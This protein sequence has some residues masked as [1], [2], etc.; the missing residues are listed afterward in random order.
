MVFFSDDDIIKGIRIKRHDVLKYIYSQ[1]FDRIKW[2]L[3]YRKNFTE[4][5]AKDIFQDSLMAIYKNI[6]KD[7]FSIKCSFKTYLFSVVKKM[8]LYRNKLRA[9]ME[10]VGNFDFEEMGV[11]NSGLPV[12]GDIIWNNSYLTEIKWGLFWKQFRNMPADCRDILLLFFKG[13][14]LN[15]IAGIKGYKSVN[16]VKKR[17]HY[18]QEYLKKYIEKDVMFNQIKDHEPE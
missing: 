14:S 15:E 7:D 12:I 5:D 8:L 3:V 2:R 16:Y 18:C 11:E 17:K 9:R 1:Y 13:E 10:T 4:E 6:L